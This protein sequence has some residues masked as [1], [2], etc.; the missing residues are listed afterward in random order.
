MQCYIYKSLNK[1]E[2]YLFLDKKDNFSCV[3]QDLLV[4]LG[5]LKFIFDIELT[6]DKKLAK[7]DA[8]MVIGKLYENGYFIQWPAIRPLT[9]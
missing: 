3:P 9:A 6:P 2:L 7:E 5:E 4:N 1:Q 8:N